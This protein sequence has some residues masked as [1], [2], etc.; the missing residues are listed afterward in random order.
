MKRE[1]GQ[2]LEVSG[3]VHVGTSLTWQFIPYFEKRTCEGVFLYWLAIDTNPL[4]NTKKMWRSVESDLAPGAVEY[5]RDV[6]AG[7]S[8]ATGAG[9]MYDV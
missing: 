2:E 1:K 5:G 7:A 9:Y 3:D 6:C 4:T 8:F